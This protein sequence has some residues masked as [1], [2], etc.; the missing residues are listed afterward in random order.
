M[1]EREPAAL[2]AHHEVY[3]LAG[4]VHDR[5]RPTGWQWRDL[6]AG[7]RERTRLPLSEVIRAV[8]EIQAEDARAAEQRAITTL[9]MTTPCP[10]C[11]KPRVLGHNGPVCVTDGCPL[12]HVHP[13]Q[14]EPRA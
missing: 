1:P 13:T 4:R 6:G 14:G 8:L 7:E 11:E 3:R 12:F 9:G 10:S 2:V 5:L